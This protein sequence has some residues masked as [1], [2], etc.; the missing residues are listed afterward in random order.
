MFVGIEQGW[1]LEHS[2]RFFLGTLD[3]DSGCGDIGKDALLFG[4]RDKVLIVND[5]LE[6]IS[7][8]RNQPRILSQWIQAKRCTVE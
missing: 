7:P 3:G 1:R 8:D 4:L 2:E 6:L 5:F